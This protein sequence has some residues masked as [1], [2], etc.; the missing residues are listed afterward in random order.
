MSRGTFL[1]L[2]PLSIRDA[3][4]VIVPIPYEAT[5]TYGGGARYGTGS[6]LGGQPSGGTVG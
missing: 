3:E 1:D 4:V 2:D 6:D 5:T